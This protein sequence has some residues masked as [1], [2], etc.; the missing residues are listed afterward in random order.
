LAQAA[1]VRDVLAYDF[2]VLSLFLSM[3]WLFL[4]IAWLFLVF[5]TVV[6]I[7]R[8]DDLGGPSKALWLLMVAVL[9]YLGVFIY[10][11]VRGRDMSAREVQRA[12]EHQDELRS[13]MRNLAGTRSTA[14]ELTKLGE[15]RSSGVLTEAEFVHQKARLLAG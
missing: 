7:F 4:W 5:R 1:Y 11:M 2:P 12:D 3:M 6:D 13:Y 14:D 15:L 10:V 8:S 9:P